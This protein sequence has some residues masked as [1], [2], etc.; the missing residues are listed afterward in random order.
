MRLFLFVFLYLVKFGE[1][2]REF[3]IIFLFVFLY[4]VKFGEDR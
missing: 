2:W 1:N 4:L 3:V